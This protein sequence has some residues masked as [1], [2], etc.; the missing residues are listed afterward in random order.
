MPCGVSTASNVIFG[1]WL[2]GTCPMARCPRGAR[3]RAARQGGVRA[4]FIDEEEVSRVHGGDRLPPGG[5]RRLIPFGGNQGF[6]LSGQPGAAQRP[7][8]RRRTERDP[9]GVRPRSHSAPPGWH[10][11][12]PGPGPAR[13]LR[14]PARCGA[15]DQGV[16]RRPA[17]P[18][19][20]RRCRQ[21]LMELSPTPKVAG[22]LSLGE[23]GV[24]GS[25]QPLAEVG[26]V[27]LHPPS[28]S[29][30]QLFRNTL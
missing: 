8:H 9:G 11:V 18:L 10:R 29:P 17:A 22:R 16:G 14:P 19:S 15:C 1:P 23:P 21:R 25:Q 6:F 5:A 4:G 13:P 28:V 2:R 3:A 7:R 12:P 26:R 24:N 27:L 30:V 20:C